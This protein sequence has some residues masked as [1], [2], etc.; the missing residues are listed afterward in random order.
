V[1][2]SIGQGV[3][4]ILGPRYGWRAPFLVISLPAMMFAILVWMFVPE[5]ERCAGEMRALEHEVV[6]PTDDGR[7]GLGGN[8]EMSEFEGEEVEVEMAEG[9]DSRTTMVAGDAP[10]QGVYVQLS[11]KDSSGGSSRSIPGIARYCNE[12]IYPHVQTLGT[13]LRCPSV[14]CCIFQGAPG[15]IPW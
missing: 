6:S 13:L 10:D 8:D 14:L 7:A 9:F 3:S 15:C 5:V 11:D 12:S 1:G 2:I 4:G